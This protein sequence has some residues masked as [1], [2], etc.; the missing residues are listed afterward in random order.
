[1]RTPLHQRK[2]RSDPRPA[3]RPMYVPCSASTPNDALATVAGRGRARL[4]SRSW[5][6]RVFPP[7]NWTY[8][9]RVPASPTEKR[10]APVDVEPTQALAPIGA[11]LRVAGVHTAT[12]SR[13]QLPVFVR[14][15]IATR[16]PSAASSLTGPASGSTGVFAATSPARRAR[17]ITPARV[18]ATL[19]PMAQQ[20]GTFEK[21]LRFGEGRRLKRLAEQAAYVATLEPDF[22]RLSDAEL[23]AKTVEFRQR[24]DNGEPLED[25]VFEAYAAVREAAKRALG[26]RIFDVQAMGGI[27]LHEADIAEM[28]TGEGKTLVAT[29]PLYLNA[30]LRNGV[31]LVTVN[32][33]LAQRD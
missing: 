18:A 19:G 2:A 14:T 12:R 16:P 15:R 33:Y 1:G 30:L 24:L 20:L 7:A 13:E 17:V 22:E 3:T 23:A 21:V 28:K 32:D 11:K 29:Q 27:V 8:A 26:Q 5:S 25:L 6:S 31:H 4:A 9:T 10:P